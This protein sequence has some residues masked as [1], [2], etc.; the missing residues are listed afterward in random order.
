MHKWAAGCLLA[1]PHT[2]SDSSSSSRGSEAMAELCGVPVPVSRQAAC[3]HRWNAALHLLL[4]SSAVPDVVQGPW[5][6]LQLLYLTDTT[7]PNS[8]CPTRLCPCPLE[9]F[10]LVQL[11]G[12]KHTVKLVTSS[13]RLCSTGRRGSPGNGECT[14]GLDLPGLRAGMAGACRCR[15]RMGWR[16]RSTKWGESRS[17]NAIIH[18]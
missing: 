16:D 14:E 1:V 18:F 5:Q 12:I 10:C 2:S 11:T 4:S 15:G 8:L 17:S 13:Y 6:Q 7:V 3:W 9:L